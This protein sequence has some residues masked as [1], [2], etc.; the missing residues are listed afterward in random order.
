MRPQPFRLERGGRIDRGEVW[1]FSFDGR[2]LAGHPGDTLASA[3]LANGVHLVGRSFKYHRPRGILGA[4]AEEPNAL[5][6]LDRGPGRVDPNLRATQIELFEGLRATS[7]NRWPSLAFDLRAINDRMAAFLPAGFYYKTFMW[8]RS[9]WHKV[10]EPRIRKA[11]GLGEAPRQ[12]DPD[13]YLHRFAHT[14]VLVVGAGPAGLMAALAAARSGARVILADD[15]PEPGGALLAEIGSTCRIEGARPLRWVAQAQAELE[16]LPEVTLLPRTTV[17]G[18]YDHNLLGALERVQD[19]EA[20]PDPALPRQRL[21]KIRAREVVLATGAIER[22]LVFANN[23]RPGVMLA[24]AAR[25]Y[26][27]RYAVAV[28]RQVLLATNNDSAYATALDLVRA[29]VKVVGVVDCRQQ[30]TGHLP[31]VLAE[32]GVPIRTA[33]VVVGTVGT[34]R[35]EQAL[36]QPVAADLVPTGPPRPVDCDTLLVSGGWSPDVQLFSQ[37]RGQL[38][39]DEA[40]ACFVPAQSFAA[41]RSAGSCAGIWTLAG[42]LASGAAAGADAATRAGFP[43]APPAAPRVEE[44]RCDPLQ[45]L[46]QSGSGKPRGRAFVDFQNDVTT[47]DIQL[48]LRE[49]FRSVE[50]VKRYTTLGMATDQGKTSNVNGLAIAAAQLGQPVGTLGTTT[51]R[52]PSNPV[53]FAAVVGP[54]RD[55]LFDPVRRT[56]T[57]AWAESQGAVFE[58]VG[59]WKRALYFPKRGESMAQ[60]VRREAMAVRKSVGIFDAS[61]LGKIDLRGPDAVELLNRVY[62]NGWSK[63]EIGRSRYGLML[64]EDGMVFD[65]GVTTRIGPDRFHMTTTTSGAARVLAWLETWVQTEWPEL[66]VWMTSITEQWAVIAVQG[67]LARRLLQD[68]TSGCDLAP[69]AF[70][71]MSMREGRVC[72]IPARIFRISFTGELGYEVNVPWSWGQALWE[73]LLEAGQRHEVVPY[74]TEAMHVLRAEKGYVIVGQETDG[75][76]TP[77]DLGMDWIVSRQKDFL[78]RRSLFRRDMTQPDRKQ[79]VGLFTDD[80]QLVLEEGAQLVQEAK[81]SVTRRS[82]G[83]VTSA[84]WSPALDRS[85]ALALVENGRARTGQRLWVAEGMRATPVTVCLPVFVDPKGERL[86][87]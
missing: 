65:D 67:P 22:P 28:G 39:F 24:A 64:R 3:L 20:L 71:H 54:A 1:T 42:C 59:T 12:P 36:V 81:P 19:H 50:H 57:H 74:G 17:F 27:N 72:G 82:I 78:G 70:P 44:P 14:D 55:G 47:K 2:R 76:V 79:L 7:Q 9:W 84:Y 26:L 16:S 61:T 56:P 80:P 5:V 30:L 32:E 87:G 6:R 48:A 21:W 11:A 51:F 8:P 66:Q 18:Y 86:H 60:A 83:H 85:I 53:T 40:A 77:Y 68:V 73:G 38:R 69:T 33:A 63:L 34:K 35:V 10:Y 29:G 41:E 62:T 15:Q 58:D 75:T 13:R 23:D 37:S 43:I 52:P 46:W 45:P 49:G 25:T 4:G 31:A